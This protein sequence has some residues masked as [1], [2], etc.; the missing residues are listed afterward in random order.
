MAGNEGCIDAKWV[1]SFRVTR[2]SSAAMRETLF[3]VSMA[4]GLI[5]DKL[6]MGVAT[7]YRVLIISLFLDDQIKL[8]RLE[9]K[10]EYKKDR[11]ES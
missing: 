7:M 8:L 4:W 3:K 2:V 9:R 11:V 5:S 6:P 1:V 10:H